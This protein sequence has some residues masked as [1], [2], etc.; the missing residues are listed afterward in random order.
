VHLGYSLLTLFP[1]RVGGSETNVR[2]LLGEFADGNG[3]ERVTVL[4]NRFVAAA[5]G[6]YERGPVSLH[7][8]RSYRAGRSVPTRALAMATA[9]ALPWLAARDVPPVD[10]VHYPV[11]VP[12][13]RSH[14]PTVV[15]IHDLQHH[16]LPEFFSRAE[17]AYRRWAYDGAARAATMVVAT[18]EY[19]RGRVVELLGIPPDRVEVVPHGLDAERFTPVADRDEAL[20]AGLDLPE[21]FVLYPANLWPHKN[22]GRLV[23]ALA[24]QREQDVDLVLTGQPWDRLERL[25]DR[26]ARLG[27]GSRVRHLGFVEPPTLAAVYRAA[28]AMVF[29]SL[30]EGFGAPPLEA[31]ACGC[32]VAASLS[33]SLRE[34][35]EGAVLELDPESVESIAH[36]LDR[37][38]VDDDLRQQLRAAGKERAT[39][40]RWSDAARRHTRVY[41]HAAEIAARPRSSRA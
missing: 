37:I 36:A 33:G 16:D 39:R 38:V 29:P 23:D 21:R 2:G 13:P 25:M 19:T 30:Y 9:R 34:V 17:R 20:L 18:S 3:P 11:T 14:C 41:A 26:A 27:V 31:M 35:C 6:E 28:C 5:Y 24:V 4:A 32:P 15:T 8:V 1:G 22:H 12:I 10:V 40:F 7:H